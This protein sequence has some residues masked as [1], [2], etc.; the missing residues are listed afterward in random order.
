MTELLTMVAGALVVSGLYVTFALGLVLVYR[1]SGVLNFAHG[2]TGAASAYAAFTLLEGGMPYAVAAVAAVVAAGA[3]S[4]LV[5]VLFIDRLPSRSHDAS[6]MIT[7]GLVLIFEGVLLGLYGGDAKTLPSGLDGPPF[8]TIGNYGIGPANALNIGAATLAV[9]GLWA[10]LYRSPAGLAVRAV[11]E[12]R[13]TA[14]LY[15][16]SGAR[17]QA[18]VWGIAGGLVGVAALLITPAYYL[19]P[20]FLTTYLIGAVT[21]VVLGG[22][23]RISG[24]VVGAVLF[25]L[26]QAAVATYISTQLAATVSFAVIF[27]VLVFFPYGLLGSALATVVEPYLP[28]PRPARRRWAPPAAVERVRAAV[29]RVRA[30]VEQVR[31]AVQRVSPRVWRLPRLRDRRWAVAAPLAVA[32]AMMALGPALTPIQLVLL[33]TVA[34]QAIAVFGTDVIFGRSGQ[35]SIGQ[36]GFMLLGGYA[37]VLLQTRLQVPFLISLVAATAL[38]AALGALFGLPAARVKGLY[39]AILTLSLALAVPEL[40]AYFPELTGGIDGIVAPLPEFLASGASRNLNVYLF[41]VAL[42]AVVAVVMGV[43]GGSASGRSWLAIRDSER[44]AAA[45]GVRVTRQRV[46]AF[47]FG[48]ALCGLSGA[49]L[50]SMT[51]Y[52]TPSTFGLFDSIYLLAAVVVGGRASVLGGVLGAAFIVGV[53]Y[54]LSGVEAASSVLL[55]CA[56]VLVLLVRPN[57]VASLFR[58]RVAAPA[59]AIATIDGGPAAA[60]A[61]ASVGGGR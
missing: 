59:P 33:A 24:V 53:P 55:G 18:L 10:L 46:V 17:V 3:L 27:V 32:A 23:E 21:A 20:D 49:L 50:A 8:V 25:S 15:G 14:S 16:I 36:A 40:I 29:E 12:G 48:S 39:L 31:A 22:F 60:P 13:V 19:T 41:A 38:A 28:R 5:F 35:L 45:C 57:G 37:C 6:G 34:A 7:L 52:I 2:A 56:L 44:A 54:L 4:V 1:A 11:S 58:R 43:V 42:C 9:G 51:G 30:A 26:V 61:G 47:S